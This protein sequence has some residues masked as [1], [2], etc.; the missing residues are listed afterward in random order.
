MRP[1]VAVAA[2][3]GLVG[4]TAAA[5]TLIDHNGQRGDG[6]VEVAQPA[7]HSGQFKAADGRPVGHVVAYTGYNGDPSWVFM[8]VDASGANGTYTCEV[9]L[10]NGISVPVG[11]FMVQDG[12]GEWAHTVSV[13]VKS[14]KAAELVGPSGATLATATVS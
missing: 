13:D 4:G 11:Q 3:M 2:A 6:S 9:K 14:I 5:V 1:A 8:N 10:S 7:L 12:V